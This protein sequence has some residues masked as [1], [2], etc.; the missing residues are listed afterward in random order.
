MKII[1]LFIMLS[2]LSTSSFAGKKRCKPLLEKLQ[3]I[4]AKQRSGYTARQGVSLQ[5]RAD[6]AREKWWR[7]ENSSQYTKSSKKKTKK[8]NVRKKA[9][10]SNINPMPLKIL[11]PFATSKAVVIQSRFKGKKQQAWLDYY[12]K[13]DKCKKVKSTK[14]FAFCME[15]KTKQ[16]QTFAQQYRP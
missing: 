12:E 15:D 11:K 13:P 7:C 1:L 2:L 9:K 4:Q 16:Q 5:N 8:K 14:V 10:E 3:N 6:K